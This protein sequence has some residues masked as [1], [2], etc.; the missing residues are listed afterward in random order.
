VDKLVENFTMLIKNSVPD[1]ILTSKMARLLLLIRNECLSAP[2][3]EKL[4]F[5]VLE[6]L[7]DLR[8]APIPNLELLLSLVA[9]IVQHPTS[10][11]EV[12]NIRIYSSV[13]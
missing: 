7:A 2:R 9:K 6:R 4:L 1:N 13:N 10:N 11:Y 3:M 8:D 5:T 12:R